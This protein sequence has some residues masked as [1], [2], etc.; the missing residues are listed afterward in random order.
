M[1]S[2]IL[3]LSVLLVGFTALFSYH[4]REFYKTYTFYKGNGFD[5]TKDFGT[6]MY[7]GETPDEA[8][9]MSNREKLYRG[10]PFALFLEALFIVSSAIILHGE[11]R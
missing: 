8:A 5:F 6:P 10:F 1:W 7:W 3:F 2:K 9:K 4:L 11:L